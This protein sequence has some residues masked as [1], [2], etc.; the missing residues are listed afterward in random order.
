M[1]LRINVP[2]NF[3]ASLKPQSMQVHFITQGKLETFTSTFSFT[4]LIFDFFMNSAI[5]FGCAVFSAFF[6]IISN[7]FRLILSIFPR[8]RKVFL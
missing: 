6:I 2:A 8:F 5:L 1:L 7:K 4:P 3:R